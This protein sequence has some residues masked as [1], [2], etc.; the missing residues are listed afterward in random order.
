MSSKIES[1][2]LTIFQERIKSGRLVEYRRT[3]VPSLLG[4]EEG[5]GYITEIGACYYD[6][7]TNRYYGRNGE[8][9]VDFS[10]DLPRSAFY[11]VQK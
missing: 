6:P 9:P 7:V 3:L 5:S 10:S 4:G 8:G 11:P 2:P 1:G